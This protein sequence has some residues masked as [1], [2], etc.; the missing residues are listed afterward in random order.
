MNRV[1]L[2]DEELATVT[3]AL[4]HW[5]ASGFCEPDRRPIHLHE[6]AAACGGGSLEADAVD[7]LCERINSGSPAPSLRCPFC[8]ST[9]LEVTAWVNVNTDEVSDSDG[10]LDYCWCPD[11]DSEVHAPEE[12]A[13]A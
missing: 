11:C 4:R 12:A 1:T 6:I 9:R 5:Q 8:K 10:P 2:S 3:A 13:P 7:E